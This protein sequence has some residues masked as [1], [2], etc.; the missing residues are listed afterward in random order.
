MPSIASSRYAWV[1]IL[2]GTNDILHNSGHSSKKAWDTAVHNIINLHIMS[3]RFGAKSVAVTIPEMDC[4]E[5]DK[6][7]CQHARLERQYINEKI[8]HYARTNE[9]TILCDLATKLP[10]P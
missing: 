8:R 10:P 3:H 1:I 6:P 4:E 2:A 7:P 9:F 5:S